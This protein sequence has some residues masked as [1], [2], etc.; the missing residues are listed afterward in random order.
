MEDMGRGGGFI[1]E[2]GITLQAD[3]PLANCLAM[4]EEV[5]EREL[6]GRT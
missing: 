2:P 4:M 6:P 5:M 3:I 1:I